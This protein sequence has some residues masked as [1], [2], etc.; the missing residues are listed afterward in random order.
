ML[1]IAKSFFNAIS[2]FLTK[3]L[4]IDGMHINFYGVRKVIVLIDVR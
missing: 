4:F 3:S 1:K 2:S